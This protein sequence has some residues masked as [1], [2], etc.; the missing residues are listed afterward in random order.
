M[1]LIELKGR[2]NL[3][4]YCPFCGKLHFDNTAYFEKLKDWDPDSEE[5]PEIP[6]LGICEH[7]LFCGMA[8][9][10][11]PLRRDCPLLIGMDDFD[12]D[13]VDEDLCLDEQI[14]QTEHGHAFCFVIRSPIPMALDS[15]VA[16]CPETEEEML[17]AAGY[18]SDEGSSS[19]TP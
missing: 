9:G 19:S 8:D 5:E 4:V 14:E 18:G 17:A 10:M 3:A 15:F 11:M 16:F 13:S 6:E 2:S 1:K 7:M 12:P